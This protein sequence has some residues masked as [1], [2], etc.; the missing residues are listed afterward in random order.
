MKWKKATLRYTFNN[1]TRLTCK[2]NY[3]SWLYIWLN[4]RTFCSHACSNPPQLYIGITLTD[5][6]CLS[7]AL[8]IFMCHEKYPDFYKILKRKPKLLKYPDF[9]RKMPNS[10]N[11]KQAKNVLWFQL[12]SEIWCRYGN[13]SVHP[14]PMFHFGILNNSA[15]AYAFFTQN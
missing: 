8:K 10:C 6:Y 15:D 9:N 7:N 4:W 3:W 5:L 13:T 1:F 11:K 2:W 12:D 14:F